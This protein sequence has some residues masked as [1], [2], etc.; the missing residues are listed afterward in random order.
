[1]TYKEIVESL[2]KFLIR[3]GGMGIGAGGPHLARILARICGLGT[4]SA[5]GAEWILAAKLQQGDKDYRD[6]VLAFP[7][8]NTAKRI[9]DTYYVEGG[10]EPGTPY[11]SLPMLNFKPS[12]L[13]L[14][15]IICG[16]FCAVWIAKQN[17]GD[18]QIA[19]NFLKHIELPMVYGLV[20]AML[21]G[22]HQVTIGAGLADQVPDVL[23][24]LAA[25]KPIKY[26]IVAPGASKGIQSRIIEVNFD[27]ADFFSS[28]LPEM[29]RPAFIPIVTLNVALDIL[30][31]KTGGRI[32]AAAF[33]EAKRSG[34]H[35]PGPRGKKYSDD[36][37]PIY[38]E[39]DRADYVLAKK[40]GIPFW[41]GGG[42]SSPEGLALAQSSGAV[43][44]QVASIFALSDDSELDPIYTALMRKL[45]YRGELEIRKDA[46]V[47]PTFYPFMVP[48]LPGT[49]SD[50]N[51]Y[52]SRPRICDLGALRQPFVNAQG[53][54]IWR[55]PAERIAIYT[56][57]GGLLE[58]AVEKRCLCNNLLAAIRLANPGELP[59][60]TLGSELGFLT[61]IMDN[62]D[63][64]YSATE[65]VNYLLS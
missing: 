44:I 27:A 25:G 7:F 15:L 56:H 29:I 51:V 3:P 65:A 19:I 16:V 45:G 13:D 1:M 22:V 47:S 55:C 5:P 50:K 52:N 48:Q 31:N 17:C 54:I 23:E 4:V 39:K 49:M 20:G 38:T 30:M 63:D 32:D 24:A 14:E 41:I 26:R 18:G 61:E 40:Q 12:Q 9:L 46:S 8:K 6:A 43:G 62:E 57:K 58:D 2:I 28:K 64:H 21:A 37:Q 59:I 11:K 10:I 42:Y 36:G 60:F 34:G 33:E 35:N 53:K